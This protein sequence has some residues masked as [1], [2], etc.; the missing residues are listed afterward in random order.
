MLQRATAFKNVPWSSDQVP[1][2][3]IFAILV[4][5]EPKNFALDA[6]TASGF[7]KLKVCYSEIFTRPM[8]VQMRVYCSALLARHNVHMT[9]RG[10]K[11]LF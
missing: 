6:K 11:R 4:F 5:V 1:L 9:N 7:L 10:K 3:E 2:P 8:L